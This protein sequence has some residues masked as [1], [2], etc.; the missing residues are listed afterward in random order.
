MCNQLI[1][2]LKEMVL[3][4]CIVLVLPKDVVKVYTLF[5]KNLVSEVKSIFQS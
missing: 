1:M 5:G 2:L 4:K 3:V